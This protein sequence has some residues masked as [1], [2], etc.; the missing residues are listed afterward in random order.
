MRRFLLLFYLLFVSVLVF[1][2]PIDQ[3]KAKL[4][5]GNFLKALTGKSV[6]NLQVYPFKYGKDV[7]MYIVYQ[8]DKFVVLS[9]DDDIKPVIAYSTDSK[10]GFPLNPE[11]K[12]WLDGYARQIDLALD[13]KSVNPGAK[14]QWEQ[15]LAGTFAYKGKVGTYLVQTTWNQSGGDDQYPY[16]YFCPDYTPVGCVATAS[17]QVLKY[18][19]Y[20]PK[21]TGWHSYYHP[22]YGQ[23][24]AI[25]D[26]TN[27]DWNSMPLD[28]SSYYVALLSYH[29]GVAFDMS[30]A[31]SGS[32]TFTY[33]LTYALPNY[34]NYSHDIKYYSRSYIE[35]RYGTQAW[36]DT[37]IKQINLRYPMVY[38]GY[39]PNAGG[40]AFVCDGY[41]SGTD[42]FHMNWGWGGS[43]DCWVTMDNISP[44]GDN[45]A[46]NDYQS[47]IAY[48]HPDRSTDHQFYAVTTQGPNEYGYSYISYIDAVNGELAY[49]SGN[50]KG[51]I[52]KTTNGGA[53]WTQVAFPSEFSAHQASM[54]YALNADTLFVP[55]FGTG[56]YL[57]RSTDGGKTWVPVLQGADHQNSFFN[58]V[59]FFDDKHGIVQGDPVDGD[60]EIYTTDDGGETWLRVVGESIPDALS[61]EYGIVG[62]YFGNANTVWFFTNKGRVFRS[63]DYGHTWDVTNLVVPTSASDPE[64]NDG[65]SCAGFVRDDGTGVIAETYWQRTSTDTVAKY[66][67]FITSDNGQTWTQFTPQGT[68]GVNQIR[69]N[70]AT[71]D[72]YSV[73]PGINYSS[74]GV[75]WSSFTDYYQLF[76]IYAL[77]FDPQGKVIYMGS[78]R[79]GLSGMT[80][81]FGLNHGII[82]GYET[83]EDRA[84][85]NTPVEFTDKSLGEVYSISWDFGEDANPPT[86]TGTGP[87]EV[88]YSSAGDKTVTLTGT[89]SLGETYTKT[90][91]FKVD[92]QV[93]DLIDKIEGETLPVYGNTYTYS[94]PYL[95]AHYKWTL[96][97]RWKALS[98]TDT[99]EI[100]VKVGGDLGQQ[101]I[102]VTPY[103]GCGYSQKTELRVVVINHVDRAYPNPSSDNVYVEDVQNAQIIVVDSKG[104]MVENFYSNDYVAILN[105]ADS[106]YTNGIYTIYV[107][108]DDGT[109][110]TLKVLVIK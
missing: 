102:D 17:A 78:G 80:W 84:C 10:P 82:P 68:M 93:P 91:V 31:R 56:T 50:V 16:N 86:A 35:G 64:N 7:V 96:P 52:V 67:Y 12:W 30:Y 9:A 29:L 20:P 47:V 73:G 65:T 14:K 69:V 27:Y 92:A 36:K 53:I 108:K 62:Y 42:M 59:H 97:A 21:G 104:N 55:V 37:L 6:D 85:V 101:V 90:F 45:T 110:R 77:D 83:S 1:A 5:A 74:D 79:Y 51:S 98:A 88:V 100:S 49:A 41:D 87:H 34:F 28:A 54:V 105:V 66:Y 22:D 39:D 58:V 33:L 48:I 11:L 75:N 94:V 70:P 38:A 107:K 2:N 3:N 24:Y 8:Q 106:K 32:G 44:E 13:K 60:F 4:A 89:N 26:T 23:L 25:F 95:D 76:N 15:L 109:T 63:V 72:F 46:F 40:H 61:G 103:N 57:L 99:N 71:G 18:W 81:R 43:G 19:N